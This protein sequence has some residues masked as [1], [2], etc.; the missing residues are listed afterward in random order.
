VPELAKLPAEAD[1]P[2]AETLLEKHP[3]LHALALG[4]EG[5]EYKPANLTKLKTLIQPWI[6]A[7]PEDIAALA[8]KAQATGTSVLDS[9]PEVAALISEGGSKLDKEVASQSREIREEIERP[10]NGWCL[11]TESDPRRGD[12]TSAVDAA[13][14]S[15][16][17]FKSDTP[18]TADHIIDDV[19]LYGGK[20]PCNPVEEQSSVRRAW[21]RVV[22]VFEVK[23]PPLFAAVTVTKAKN[24]PAA[25]GEAPPPASKL[26]GATPVTVV[27]ER[28]LGNRRFIPFVFS[29]ISWIMF[30]VFVTILHY[31]DKS[32][33]A[34]RS[35][36]KPARK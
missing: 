10:L 24:L 9:N 7:K 14:I 17:I 6:I 29:V 31:R 32:Q 1:L 35:S 16:K 22:S 11:L 20:V 30:G 3:L 5:A 33:M 28:N 13:L 27:M 25:A 19:F 18:T 8:K 26:E 36:F 21:N 2:V 12:A 15:Q 34:I 4:S 23:N